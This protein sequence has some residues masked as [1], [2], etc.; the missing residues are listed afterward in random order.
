VSIDLGVVITGALDPLFDRPE[1]FVILAGGNASN[2]CPY[3]CGLM[4]IEPGT[5]PEIWQLF[6]LDAA[7]N[8]PW[9][10][11]PDDQSWIYHKLPHAAVWNVGPQSGVWSFKKRNW[12][13]GDELPEGA[14]LVVFPG[15]RKPQQFMHLPWVRDH[16]R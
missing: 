13:P 8:V 15:S 16:W 14:R 11:F 3:N 10:A 5:Y 4:M 6:S 1:K 9:Y 7:R 2:P 12:P